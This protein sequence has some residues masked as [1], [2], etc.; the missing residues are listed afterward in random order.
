[1]EEDVGARGSQLLSADAISAENPQPDRLLLHQD[2]MPP[3]KN[4]VIDGERHSLPGIGGFWNG[5]PGTATMSGRRESGQTGPPPDQKGD[6]FDNGTKLAV[7]EW[8]LPPLILEDALDIETRSGSSDNDSVF[9]TPNAEDDRDDESFFCFRV[10]Y[11][12][13]EDD[14]PEGL[15]EDRE[16]DRSS[17]TVIFSS[18]PAPVVP[19]PVPACNLTNQPSPNTKRGNRK[20]P[21][22]ESSQSSQSSPHEPAQQITVC[23]A[24]VTC[25]S[26]TAAKKTGKA[27]ATRTLFSAGR[28]PRVGPFSGSAPRPHPPSV[29][30]CL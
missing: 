14:Q 3:Q 30:G 4:G 1:M 19:V 23:D 21:G 16:T 25:T 10:P 7:P 6:L 2:G 24:V 20:K 22:R 12:T 18:S 26:S 11:P 13:H 8:C 17:T 29:C 27:R 15:G 9:Y 28:D 5:G